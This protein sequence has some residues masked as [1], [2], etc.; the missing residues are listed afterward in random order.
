[1]ARIFPALEAETRPTVDT[2]TAAYYLNY[3]TQT[4]RYWSHSGT[5]LPLTEN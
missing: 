5:V 4:L 2:A 1:M 3:A